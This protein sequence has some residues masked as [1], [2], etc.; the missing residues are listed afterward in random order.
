MLYRQILSDAPDA[1]EAWLGLAGSDR[2]PPVRNAPLVNVCWPWP[3]S[4]PL[5]IA[6]LAQLDGRPVPPEVAAA[7]AE[8]EAT[9]KAATAPATDCLD[10]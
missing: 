2:R 5:A 3:P 9:A 1:E 6:A 4:T 8:A 10:R 7:L